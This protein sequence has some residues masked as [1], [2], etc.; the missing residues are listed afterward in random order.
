MDEA[1]TIAMMM[2]MSGLITEQDIRINTASAREYIAEGYTYDF[3]SQTWIK[4]DK[5]T[6]ERELATKFIE[7]RK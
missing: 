2:Y 6:P 1:E 3:A 5:D 7:G 4:H